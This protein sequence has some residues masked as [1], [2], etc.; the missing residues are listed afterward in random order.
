VTVT[1]P[2][3]YQYIEYGKLAYKD[4]S[5]WLNAPTFRQNAN[6]MPSADSLA[7]VT[8]SARHVGRK[9]RKRHCLDGQR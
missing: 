9:N 5:D 3:G 4:K 1:L 2:Y 7:T 8:I 6:L